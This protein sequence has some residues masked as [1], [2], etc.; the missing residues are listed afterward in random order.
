MRGVISLLLVDGL[1][2][3]TQHLMFRK[4]WKASDNPLISFLGLMLLI[5]WLLSERH[6]RLSACSLKKKLK[7]SRLIYSNGQ[8][9][10]IIGDHYKIF[11]ELSLHASKSKKLIHCCYTVERGN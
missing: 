4:W 1:P 5:W 7:I 8:A 2:F 3:Q 6:N 9:S 11:S 10:D